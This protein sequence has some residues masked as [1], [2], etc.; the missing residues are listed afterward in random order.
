MPKDPGGSYAAWVW[1]AWKELS[2][3]NRGG[4]REREVRRSFNNL[5]VASGGE[6]SNCRANC[7]Q[8]GES[9]ESKVGLTATFPFKSGI[10]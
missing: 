7:G 2:S 4:E 1:A 5:R 8:Y 3:L 6:K 10:F 9:C